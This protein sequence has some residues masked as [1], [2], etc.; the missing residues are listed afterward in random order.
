MNNTTQNPLCNAAIAYATRGFAVLPCAPRGKAPATP[1]GC[2]DATKDIAQIAGWWRENPNYNVAFATGA[3]SRIF[4]LDVDGLDAEASLHQLEEQHGALPETVESITPRGRHIFFR[5]E[6]AQVKNSAGRLAHGLDIRG[7]GGYVVLPPSIHPSGRPYVWSVDSADHFAEAPAWLSNLLTGKPNGHCHTQA[8]SP[9]HWHSVIGNTIRNG[10]RN[11]T[12]TSI[13]GKLLHA[14]LTELAFLYDVM[15][16]INIARCEE[17]LPEGEVH[18]IVVSVARTHLKR[19][20]GD[21]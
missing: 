1:H 18:T 19:L 3:V 20:R 21:A 13:S 5:C 12:L 10:A 6:N 8:K 15:C 4:V 11:S 17:P 7:D 2:R 9:E 16:C 14:G